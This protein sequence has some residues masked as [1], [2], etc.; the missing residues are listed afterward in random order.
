MTTEPYP[1]DRPAIV[2]IGLPYANGPLHIGHLRGFFTGDVF[3][4]ALRKL[5]Q[6][7]VVISGSDLHGTPVALDAAQKGLDPKS[8]A[9]EWH[10]QYEQ[11][12]PQFNIEIDY[13]GNTHEQKNRELTEEFV[14][15]WEQADLIFEET[16]EVTWDPTR[17]QPLPD[18]FVEGTCPYCGATA[19]GDECDE[20]CQRHLEPGEIENPRSVL[21]GTP[22]EFRTRPHKFLRLSEFEEYLIGFL[23]RVEGTDNARNQPREWINQ[24]LRDLCITRDLDWGFPYPDDP[25]ER[26]L[27][28]WIDAPVEY[29]AA[30]KAYATAVDEGFEW[31]NVWKAGDGEIIHVIG[32]DI[33]QHHCLFWPAMLRG[34]DYAE[35]RA[36]CATGFV[37]FEGRR[38]STSRGHA[39]WAEEYLEADLHPDLLR[40]YLVTESNIQSDLDFTWDRFAERVNTE[41]VGHLGNFVHRSLIFAHRHWGGTPSGDTSDAVISEISRALDQFEAAVN[42]YDVSRLGEL[43]IELAR[44]G[45]RFIQHHEPWKYIKEDE[46]EAAKILR[47]C[48]Q[49]SK[50]IAVLIQPTTPRKAERIWAALEESGSVKQ[51]TLQA[52]LQAPPQT[53]EAP[54]QVFEPIYERG[55]LPRASKQ[56][57]TTTNS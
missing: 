35:P 47:D 3:A 54:E 22:A 33:I 9:L 5:G 48:V 4:R 18:R 26:V 44:F 37:T 56:E 20:G 13:Y 29:V 42:E 52:A 8:Y 27:Y 15:A 57:D 41:L 36:V 19:R 43:P 50:A 10:R 53:F 21:T 12:L 46:T 51:Q 38:L 34:S 31:A 32:K 25:L 45:N 28:V 16:I 49:L 40:Y 7:T 24:G 17:D 2:T 1:T 55:S 23:D 30:T 14:R 11:K 39:V 6:E